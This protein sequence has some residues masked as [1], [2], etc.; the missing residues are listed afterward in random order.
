ME[1]LYAAL[2]CYLAA[3]TQRD[4]RKRE[5]SVKN[6]LRFV[7]TAL[8]LW[9]GKWIMGRISAGD[10]AIEKI[11]TDVGKSMVFIMGALMPGVFLLMLGRVTGQAVGYGDGLLLLTCGLYL[12]G[13]TAG[14]LF[15]GGLF[16]LF[17]VSLYLLISGMAKRKTQL[18]FA[19]FLL[20]AFVLWL[21]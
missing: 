1:Y 21:I 11:L 16:L 13:R 9:T 14:I 4:I 20:T 18:P 10:F 5:I 3:E 12:G 19:P 17:P 15:V 2:L 6:T 8:L 7:V